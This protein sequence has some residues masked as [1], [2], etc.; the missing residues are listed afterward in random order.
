MGAMEQLPALTECIQQSLLD[1]TDAL[2]GSLL[3]LDAG[4]GE[5]AQTT[6]GLP[7][8][9]G[10]WRVLAAWERVCEA[11]GGPCTVPSI[12]LS[13]HAW[14][15]PHTGL[16]VVHVCSLEDASPEDAL[17]PTLATGGPPATLSIFTT[18]LLTDVHPHVLRAVLVGAVG[19]GLR[20]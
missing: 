10:G 11:S 3:Y 4:A 18:Q 1:H 9:L 13:Q 7:L 15:K 16:G 17:L 5:V 8:L 6:L 20:A 19:W 12:H 2:R 14:C